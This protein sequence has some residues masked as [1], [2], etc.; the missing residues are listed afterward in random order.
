MADSKNV[1]VGTRVEVVG[2]G[3]VG[4]VAFVGATLFSSGLYFKCQNFHLN[5]DISWTQS[6]I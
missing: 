2:K 3:I 4:T 1:K 6:G 5:N